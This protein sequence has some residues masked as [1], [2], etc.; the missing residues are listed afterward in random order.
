MQWKNLN[1]LALELCGL[2][3]NFQGLKFVW[4]C[5]VNDIIASFQETER[6]RE[7][8]AILLHDVW[9]STVVDFEC[10]SSR[11]LWI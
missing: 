11:I 8:E 2:N 4:W 1:V 10:V 5:G 7:G 6:A 3:S 9:H